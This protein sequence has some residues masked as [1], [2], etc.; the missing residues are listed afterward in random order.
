MKTQFYT[1]EFFL[2][3]TRFFLCTLTNIPDYFFLSPVIICRIMN[4]NNNK[5]KNSKFEKE[6]KSHETQF[7]TIELLFFLSLDVSYEHS[8]V[9]PTIFFLSLLIPPFFVECFF[10]LGFYFAWFLFSRVQ[11]ASYF[12]ENPI[13]CSALFFAWFLFSRV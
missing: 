1:I 12:R 11:N 13:F 9:F 5:N 10:S 7:Y 3:F 8:E 4:A 2:S 6:A